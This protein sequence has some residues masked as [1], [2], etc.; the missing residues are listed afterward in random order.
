MKLNIT[1]SRIGRLEGVRVN[2]E[3]VNVLISY[4]L[5]ANIAFCERNLPS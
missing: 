4:H 3:E 1:L 2:F 5:D